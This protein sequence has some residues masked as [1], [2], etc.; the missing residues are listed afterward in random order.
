MKGLNRDNQSTSILEVKNKGIKIKKTYLKNVVIVFGV[1]V[2]MLVVLL[3]DEDKTYG[4][5]DTNLYKETLE[6]DSNGNLRM[7]THD[8]KATSAIIYRTIGW[9]IKRYDMPINARGQQYAIIPVSN[10]VEYRDDPNNPAYMYCYYTGTKDTI[11]KVI[12]S[13]SKE[14]KNQLFK[15][16]DHVYIDEIMTVVERGNVLGGFNADGK[17]FWGEV[18][19]DYDGISQARPWASKESLKTHYD[20]KVYFPSQVKEKYFRK[21]EMKI[22]EVTNKKDTECKMDIGEGSKFASRYDIEKSSANRRIT[23]C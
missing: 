10:N 18:Y 7:T 5:A 14:W 11:E 16:G 1:M 2:I 21:T 15:Y 3:L 13:V 20:K 8:K 17:S 23:L 6:F 19:F 22:G 4:Y 12:D 9:V